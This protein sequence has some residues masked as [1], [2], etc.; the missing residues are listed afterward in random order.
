MAGSGHLFLPD[1]SASAGICLASV[2][3]FNR[4]AEGQVERIEPES[5]PGRFV[6]ERLIKFLWCP[7]PI[8]CLAAIMITLTHDF[9][10]RREDNDM[11]RIAIRLQKPDQSW[12]IGA[13]YDVLLT[14]GIPIVDIGACY[15]RCNVLPH[16]DLRLGSYPVIRRN[17]F[18]TVHDHLAKHVSAQMHTLGQSLSQCLRNC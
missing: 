13:N 17:D 10:C 8:P 9:R 7:I 14:D 1:V 11:H 18:L 3:C 4:H 16:M 12:Q 5:K 2:D 6:S 15:A